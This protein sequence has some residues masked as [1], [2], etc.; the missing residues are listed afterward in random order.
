MTVQKVMTVLRVN[1]VQRSMTIQR[2][3]AQ[4]FGAVNVLELVTRSGLTL[5]KMRPLTA[6]W[7]RS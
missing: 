3:M 5:V 6:T 1:T 7:L 4:V 2:L